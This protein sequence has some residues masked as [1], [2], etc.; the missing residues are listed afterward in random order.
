MSEIKCKSCGQKFDNSGLS[1]SHQASDS[2]YDGSNNCPFCGADNTVHE[3][4]PAPEPKESDLSPTIDE[5]PATKEAQPKTQT[6]SKVRV[7][8]EWEANWKSTPIQAYI[9]TCK[10]VILNPTG[11][12][13]TIKPFE[14]WMSLAV[15][16]YINTFLG[17]IGAI[18]TKAFVALVTT[19]DAFM[20]IPVLFC[21]AI[22]FPLI[23]VGLYFLFAAILHLFFTSIGGSEKEYDTTASVYGLASISQLFNLIPFVGGFISFVYSLIMMIGGMAEA[24]EISGGKSFLSLIVP[25]LICCCLGFGLMALAIMVAGGIG[26]LMENFS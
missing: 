16:I 8:C 12:F 1:L 23:A 19:A 4:E 14:D 22:F 5:V 20:S 2:K 13:G 15:F 18:A 21:M 17:F 11:Y 9:N 26:S 10:S 24:H 3:P 6:A 7:K 25:V